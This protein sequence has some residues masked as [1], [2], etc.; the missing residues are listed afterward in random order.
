MLSVDRLSDMSSLSG[1]STFSSRLDGTCPAKAEE[2][3]AVDHTN[4]TQTD[5]S[6]QVDTIGRPNTEGW[7]RDC[8]RTSEGFCLVVEFGTGGGAGTGQA[9]VAAVQTGSIVGVRIT[10]LQHRKV[11]CVSLSKRWDMNN[12]AQERLFTSIQMQPTKLGGLV[13]CNVAISSCTRR[14]I[15][16]RRLSLLRFSVE[17]H[18]PEPQP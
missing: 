7:G 16:E 18:R 4:D 9:T 3:P 13:I 14:D 15:S 12:E 10:L 1:F 17:A 2:R 5:H 11:G 8:G 6:V